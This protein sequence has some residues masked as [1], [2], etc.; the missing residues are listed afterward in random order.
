MGEKCFKDKEHS[1][2]RKLREERL[3][4]ERGEFAETP[5][6]WT[7]FVPQCRNKVRVSVSLQSE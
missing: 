4:R 1:E 3:H 6:A 7:V 5:L 2:E